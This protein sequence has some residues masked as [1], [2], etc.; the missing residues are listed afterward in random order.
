MKTEIE[1]MNR[2]GEKKIYIGKTMKASID[3]VTAQMH[4]GNTKV[5]S[6]VNNEGK[7]W[8]MEYKDGKI[9]KDRIWFSVRIPN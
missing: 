7:G 8:F 5:A 3:F 9:T 4:E 6:I 1:F 2:N